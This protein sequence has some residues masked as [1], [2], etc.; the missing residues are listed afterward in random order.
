MFGRK[1]LRMGD[2]PEVTTAEETTGNTSGSSPSPVRRGV[3]GARPYI[4]RAD[5]HPPVTSVGGRGIFSPST[6]SPP[7]RQIGA[8]PL[9]SRQLAGRSHGSHSGGGSGITGYSP[10]LGTDNPFVTPEKPATAKKHRDVGDDQRVVTGP[11]GT[12]ILVA[13]G[14]PRPRI[15]YPEDRV[16]KLHGPEEEERL[17]VE[18]LRMRMTFDVECKFPFC[19]S[20]IVHLEEVWQNNLVVYGEHSLFFSPASPFHFPL[21]S[22]RLIRR[23][24]CPICDTRYLILAFGGSLYDRCTVGSSWLEFGC[25]ILYL[26]LGPGPSE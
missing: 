7:L 5:I 8:K 6:T 1:L 13:G 14:P 2:R 10:A 15:W 26:L 17:W 18:F 25:L 3:L 23:M 20:R 12:K 16:K 24:V 4:S 19:N 22:G 21:I 11:A 9:I